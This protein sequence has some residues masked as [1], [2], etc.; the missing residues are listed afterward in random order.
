[1]ASIL[2]IQSEKRVMSMRAARPLVMSGYV[3]GGMYAETSVSKDTIEALR[4]RIEGSG[5]SR[6]RSMLM[7]GRMFAWSEYRIVLRM[8]RWRVRRTRVLRDW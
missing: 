8:E 2:L 7:V 3:V 6:C 4:A 1:M 5:A